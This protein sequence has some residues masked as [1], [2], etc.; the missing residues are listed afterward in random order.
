MS[1]VFGNMKN[2]WIGMTVVF[3]NLLKVVEGQIGETICACTPAS[4]TFR[5]RFDLTCPGN[6]QNSTGI[7]DTD[8]TLNNLG[9]PANTDF[10]PVD[11]SRVEILELNREFQTIKFTEY[12]DGFADNDTF[13]YVS[14]TAEDSDL[15]E[16]GITRFFQSTVSGR[17][18]AGDDI[19]NVWVIE[20]TNECDIFP[21]FSVGDAIG[22]LEIIDFTFPINRYCPGKLETIAPG[23]TTV[24]PLTCIYVPTRKPVSG[25]FKKPNHIT[26]SINQSF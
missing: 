8:C 10:I 25:S 3:F 16:A 6:I 11:V 19:S 20:L 22:W 24:L 17:N 5:V 7:E 4:Y 13:E 23:T 2:S 12:A 14:I 15:T 18:I 9:N 1:S 21:I 26:R